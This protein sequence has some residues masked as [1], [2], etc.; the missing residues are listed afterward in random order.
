MK[1]YSYPLQSLVVSLLLSLVFTLY[2]F[3][4]WRRTVSSNFFDTQ[5]SLISNE[6]HVL[7]RHA[8]CVLSRLCCN[9][10]SLSLSSYL[11]RIGRID[12]T[13]CSACRHL[14]QDTSQLIL[15]CLWR[16]SVSQKFLVQALGSCGLLGLD[17]FPSRPH[18]S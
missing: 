2:L 4:D 12:N 15:Y 3:S 17:G 18:L 16:L 8:R 9:G 5:V 11:T 10:H 6:E 13:S 7:P 14:S 1:R